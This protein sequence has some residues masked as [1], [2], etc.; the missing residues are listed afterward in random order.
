MSKRKEFAAALI[1]DY[2]EELNYA[3][4]T[5]QFTMK[6]LDGE[7]EIEIDSITEGNEAVGVQI[8]INGLSELEAKYT[9]DNFSEKVAKIIVQSLNV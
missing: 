4:R 2:T 3:E 5:G 8:F 9:E 6:S 1:D 7:T